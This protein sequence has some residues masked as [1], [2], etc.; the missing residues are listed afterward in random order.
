[1]AASGG[2]KR[3]AHHSCFTEGERFVGVPMV[4][5]QCVDEEVPIQ[6]ASPIKQTTTDRSIQTLALMSANLVAFLLSEQRSTLVPQAK[7]CINLRVHKGGEV[8]MASAEVGA[9]F[10]RLLASGFVKGLASVDHD[11]GLD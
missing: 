3:C 10:A 7:P 1:M 5:P 6:R 8:E 4:F 11:C 2:H 9:E